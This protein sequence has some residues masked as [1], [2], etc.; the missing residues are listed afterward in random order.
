MYYKQQSYIITGGPGAGKTSVLDVLQEQGYLV[1]PEV[2]RNIIR[3]Q[4]AMDGDALPWRNTFLYKQIMA[5]R[6]IHSFH[7]APGSLCLFDRGIPD[8][9]AYGKLIGAA[10]DQA[11]LE[12]AHTC[13]CNKQVFIFPP[14]KEIYTMD[15]ER[16][17][18]FTEAI[19]TFDILKET[20]VEYGYELIEVPTGTVAQR[21]A[22]ISGRVQIPVAK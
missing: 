6:T 2:A 11:L 5:E 4:M 10:A 19:A 21:A 17:Q 22:F 3:E 16:K 14:W 18:D 20:Y 7:E 15:T 12:A 1:M 13:R 8:V 9:I